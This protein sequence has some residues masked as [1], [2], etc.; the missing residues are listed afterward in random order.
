MSKRGRA[1]A[2]T[3]NSIQVILTTQ[4]ARYLHITCWAILLLP[5]TSLTVAAFWYVA[6]IAAGAGRSY[7]ERYLNKRKKGESLLTSSQY[8]FI[9][10][11]SC[12]FWAAAPVIAVTSGHPY[13]AAAAM[14]F[15]I[16]GYMLAF[17]QFRTTPTNALLATSPYAVAYVACLG[18]VA[19][20]SMFTVMIAALPVFIASVSYVLMYGVLSQ[21]ELDKANDDREKLIEELEEAW[22]A[23]ERASA[24]KSMFLANMSHEIRTPMNGVL[25]MAELLAATRLDNS[26]RIFAD[27]IHKSGAALLTIINDILDFS[28]IE[29][30]RLH[31]DVAPFDLQASIEDVA[32]LSTARAQ[33][34][35]IEIIIRF[36]PDLPTHLSGDGGRIRQIVTNLVGNAVKFTSE[37][38]VLIDVSGVSEND[39]SNFRISVKDTGVG[40]SAEKV[41]KIFDAFE[42]ADTTTTREFG[43]TGLGLSISKKLTEAMGGEISVQSVFGKGSTFSIDLSLPVEE[44][45]ELSWQSTFSA[46]GRRILIVDDI[47]V[48][49]DILTEQL[50]SWGFRTETAPSGAKAL[51]ELAEAKS[52]GDPFALAILDFMMPEMDGEELAQKIRENDDFADTKLMVLT[53]VDRSNESHRLREL[54]VEAYLV[55]PARASLIF[56]TLSGVFKEGPAEIEADDEAVAEMPKVRNAPFTNK[57]KILLAEDNEVNQLVIKHMLSPNEFDL[58]VVGDGMAAFETAKSGETFDVVLMDISMPILDGYEAARRIREWERLT[59]RER[60]P[61]VCLTAHVL[62][63]DMDRCYAAGMDDFIAKPVNRE[64][65]LETIDRALNSQIS[66]V[67]D[68]G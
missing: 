45:E 25:G 42:Q 18:V 13:G 35:D 17:A 64:R 28:K 65:L 21:R 56:E 23:A 3:D 47:D 24:A 61:I 36:Q 34:K 62:Q 10:M 46:D 60:M 41:E 31:L 44:P 15:I 51:E 67:S 6:T 40:I 4:Y 48:N 38:Y 27:T 54:G 19:G 26:Q 58:T 7:L 16:N 43:G 68:V 29:A 49:R 30:G 12:S 33:E 39:I 63:E 32:A 59:S 55:K 22:V 2:Q 66:I 14:F 57:V 11:A 20:T 1:D 5:L 52:A 8:G 53:S 9:A 50:R 37:G